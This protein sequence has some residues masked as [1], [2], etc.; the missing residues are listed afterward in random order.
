MTVW[1]LI[2]GVGFWNLCEGNSV[3]AILLGLACWLW[4]DFE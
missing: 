4:G 2:L 1:W 3:I